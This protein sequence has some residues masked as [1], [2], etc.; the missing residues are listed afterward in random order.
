[1]PEIK[2]LNLLTHVLDMDTIPAQDKLYLIYEKILE[3]VKTNVW[4]KKQNS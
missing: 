3:E 1:M 2:K 4:F